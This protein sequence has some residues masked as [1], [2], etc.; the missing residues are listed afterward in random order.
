MS[1]S[2][3]PLAET[4]GAGQLAIRVN[5]ENPNHH[6]WNNNGVWFVHYTVHPDALTARRVRRSLGTRDLGVARQ[7]RDQLLYGSVVI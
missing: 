2:L 6:L 1:Y 4:R 3:L 5:K 7:R